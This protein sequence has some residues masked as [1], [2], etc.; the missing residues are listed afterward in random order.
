MGVGSSPPSPHPP[1]RPV[2][3]LDFIYAGPIRN[4]ACGKS[5][6]ETNARGCLRRMFR[7]VFHVA[8]DFSVVRAISRGRGKEL[9]GELSELSLSGDAPSY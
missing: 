7:E 6:S 5:S 2:K 8:R 9:T 1:R 4:P 3:F